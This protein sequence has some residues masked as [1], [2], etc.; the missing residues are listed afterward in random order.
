M[1]LFFDSTNLLNI[2]YAPYSL[3]IFTMLLLLLEAFSHP[4][5]LLFSF[6]YL[7]ECPRKPSPNTPSCSGIRVRSPAHYCVVTYLSFDFGLWEQRM[8]I[9]NPDLFDKMKSQISVCCLLNKMG[10]GILEQRKKNTHDKAE[11][12]AIQFWQPSNWSSSLNSSPL[13]AYCPRLSHTHKQLRLC[14]LSVQN[15]N[16]IP[17]P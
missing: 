2:Y 7:S 8:I 15:S 17:S 5:A 10:M 3:N 4:Y 16:G 9:F 13:T 14:H 6:Y 12:P 11:F 1:H